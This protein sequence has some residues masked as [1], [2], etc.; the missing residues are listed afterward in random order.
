M[1]RAGRAP[2]GAEAAA[3]AAAV[4]RRAAGGRAAP[5]PAR[6]QLE[7]SSNLLR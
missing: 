2:P 3:A 7:A 4:C 1:P 6:P 5:G